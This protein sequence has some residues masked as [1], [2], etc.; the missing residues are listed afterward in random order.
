MSESKEINISKFKFNESNPRLIKD[1]RFEELKKSISEF[2]KMLELRPVVYDPDTMAVLGG[3]MRLRE[4]IDLGYK[5]IPRTW[6][7]SAKDLTEEERKRFVIVDNV[8]FGEWDYDI[9]ANQWG[10]DELRE[11]GMKFDFGEMLNNIQE[12]EEIEIEQSVQIEPPREYILIMADPNS[13]EWEELK[14]IL[15]LRMLRRGGYKKGSAFDH[16]GL[17]RVIEWRE[18][19]KRYADSNTK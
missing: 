3:N 11:W 7:K 14:Q 19:K 8:G 6:T 9:L 12:G 2:P 4:L 16:V 18:F 1:H 15:K 13:I 5:K 10:E 17:E